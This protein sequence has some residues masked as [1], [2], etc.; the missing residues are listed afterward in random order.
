MEEASMYIDEYYIK[1]L[2]TTLYKYTSGMYKLYSN[3]EHC[4]DLL[5]MYRKLIVCICKETYNGVTKLNDQFPKIK[6]L[7][8]IKVCIDNIKKKVQ[9][10][11]HARAALQ[12]DGEKIEDDEISNLDFYKLRRLFVVILNCIEDLYTDIGSEHFISRY[13]RI[14]PEKKC[15]PEETL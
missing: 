9:Q 2:F 5:H 7:G 6:T 4:T 11:A 14:C 10:V 3:D 15:K 1:N 13:K 12:V 8:L